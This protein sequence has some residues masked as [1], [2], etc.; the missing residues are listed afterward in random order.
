MRQGG[1]ELGL[2]DW[3]VIS[4]KEGEWRLQRLWARL[5]K[6]AP[7]GSDEQVGT[8]WSVKGWGLVGSKITNIGDGGSTRRE[9]F[10]C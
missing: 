3:P 7:L 6:A 9:S 10:E 8:Y 5:H 4:G 2:K 1:L